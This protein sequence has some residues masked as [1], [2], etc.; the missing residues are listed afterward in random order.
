[1]AAGKEK[2]QSIIPH[3]AVVSF[4]RWLSFWFGIG[5]GGFL[6]LGL[7]DAAAA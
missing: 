1:M 6:Q 7:A 3:T 2:P 5:Y 4:V